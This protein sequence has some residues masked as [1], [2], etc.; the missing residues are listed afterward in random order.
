[1]P[2]GPSERPSEN[3]IHPRYS[4]MA[5]GA[6]GT[7]TANSTVSVTAAASVTDGVDFT[8]TSHGMAVG[9][10]CELSGFTT[11]TD[12]NGIWIVTGV[13]DANSFIIRQ[14]GLAFGTSESGTV[15]PGD[16]ISGAVSAMAAVSAALDEQTGGRYYTRRQ[17]LLANSGTTFTIP[18]NT[19]LYI[20]PEVL[21]IVFE[22]GYTNTDHSF[23][24]SG[25][26]LIVGRPIVTNG[27]TRYSYG[28]AIT[29]MDDGR[30]RSND[31]H[32]NIEIGAAGRMDWYGGIIKVTSGT[33]HL[34][35]GAELFTY[36]D[37]CIYI[38]PNTDQELATA[39]ICMGQIRSGSIDANING[40]LNVDGYN[41]NANA[42]SQFTMQITP[43][44]PVQGYRPIHCNRG[45]ATSSSTSGTPE[46]RGFDPQGCSND[47]VGFGSGFTNANLINNETG[48]DLNWE[49]GSD[50]ADFQATVQHEYTLT[51][52]DSSAAEVAAELIWFYRDTDNGERRNEHTNNLSDNTYNGGSGDL[53][54]F[55]LLY[56]DVDDA[57]AAPPPAA[58]FDYR[59][60]DGDTSDVATI[61]IWSYL[62]LPSTVTAVMKGNN[63]TQ[64]STTIFDDPNVTETTRATVDAYT[65]IDNGEELYD[66]SKSEKISLTNDI[67]EFPDLST[68]LI[69]GLGTILDLGDISLTIDGGA[70]S[71]WA[72]NQTG[73]GRITIDSGSTFASTASGFNTITTTGDVTVEDSTTIDDW[74][75]DCDLILN[76]S[77]NLNDVAV[78]SGHDITVDTA[79]SDTLDW[80]NVS[81]GAGG[82][83]TVNQTG[84]GS[85][86]INATNSNLTAG[87]GNVTI[88]NNVTITIMVIDPSGNPLE[89]ARVFLEEDPGGTD[90]IDGVTDSLTNAS[91]IVTATYSYTGDQDV[92]GRV[93]L[94][95]SSPFY[96]T[97]TIA[98]TITSSGFSA[99][100]VMILDE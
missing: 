44:N 92:V 31:N 12:Y 27:F 39:D 59:L 58:N 99:T 47:F 48:T 7:L 91:G 26:H 28:N 87:T 95:T 81:N 42:A 52:F 36:S 80:D 63:G 79:T 50:S 75:F 1:M 74:T 10:P 65:T 64:Q 18:A 21:E 72:L 90:I 25:G 56:V 45:F 30:V 24:V 86:T 51:V 66:R 14:Q 17:V 40:L 41:T 67:I 55:D 22:D 54:T 11:N 38:R 5:I 71:A 15:R 37:N 76:T 62:H 96:K 85:I 73:N 57:I 9:D 100:I 93:R 68:G 19:I 94:S 3:L 97:G 69:A 2:A 49:A 34:D 23:L 78:T 4:G 98:G 53:V 13:P 16:N 46:L 89:N 35:A 6:T 33:F 82:S 70:A 60:E 77:Q 29:F 61:P 20:D 88:N 43:T 83:V 84:A 8:A 32:S